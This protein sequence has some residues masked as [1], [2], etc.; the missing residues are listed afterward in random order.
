V[1]KLLLVETCRRYVAAPAETF[2]LKVGLVEILVAALAGVTKTG[3]A[4][5]AMVVKLHMSE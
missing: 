1:A 4:G 2:Q 3:D 5:T